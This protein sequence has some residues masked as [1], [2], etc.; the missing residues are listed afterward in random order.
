MTRERVRSLAQVAILVT[1]ARPAVRRFSAPALPYGT[2][3]GFLLPGWCDL[4]K[5]HSDKSAGLGP[6]TLCLLPA[7]PAVPQIDACLPASF[8]DLRIEREAPG[9]LFRFELFS[10]ASAESLLKHHGAG[11]R[12]GRCSSRASSAFFP[13]RQLSCCPSPARRS[14]SPMAASPI[15]QVFADGPTTRS[16]FSLRRAEAR[17]ATRPRRAFQPLFPC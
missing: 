5:Q 13:A 1:C 7:C 10:T 16:P 3:F 14:G 9:A 6:R 2:P 12:I 17:L 15:C 4:V 11:L 8:P